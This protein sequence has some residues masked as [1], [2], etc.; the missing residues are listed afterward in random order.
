V[1]A[2][3][4][5]DYARPRGEPSSAKPL[6]MLCSVPIDIERA[7]SHRLFVSTPGPNWQNGFGA[8]MAKAAQLNSNRFRRPTA[9]CLQLANCA[10]AKKVLSI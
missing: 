4:I 5:P 7:R 3:V 2:V 10:T 1:F 6:V 8:E 9:T